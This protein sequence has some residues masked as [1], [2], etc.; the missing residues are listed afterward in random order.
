MEA[1]KR[2]GT[3][4]NAGGHRRQYYFARYGHE[5]RG[6]NDQH[7]TASAN[8]SREYGVIGRLFGARRGCLADLQ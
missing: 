5:R 1:A 6:L 2:H 3:V 7:P 4:L 8:I